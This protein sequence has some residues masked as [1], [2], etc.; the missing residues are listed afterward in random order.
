MY[1]ILYNDGAISRFCGWVGEVGVARKSSSCFT[2]REEG[3]K[4][5]VSNNYKYW[6]VL[7][8]LFTW[9]GTFTWQNLPYLLKDYVP[10]IQFKH[11]LLQRE[12]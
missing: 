3:V 8:D 6:N 5:T 7:G 1:V 10:L 2:D 9:E 12:V 11:N 4:S